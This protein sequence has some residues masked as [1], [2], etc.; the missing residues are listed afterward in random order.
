MAEHKRICFV[1]GVKGHTNKNCPERAKPETHATKISHGCGNP[2]L[3]GTKVERGTCP[4]W[5]QR[6]KDKD[7]NMHPYDVLKEIFESPPVGTGN[8]AAKTWEDNRETFEFDEMMD[9]QK[10]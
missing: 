3:F 5:A 10:L 1:C 2:L 4:K 7:G 8:R 6:Q 9:S